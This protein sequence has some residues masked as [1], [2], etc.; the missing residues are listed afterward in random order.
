MRLGRIAL[1]LVWL[2]AGA[3]W[4][5][6]EALQAYLKGADIPLMGL[7][8]L[9]VAM[10]DD[11]QSLIR[12]AKAPG[13]NAEVAARR[14]RLKAYREKSARMGLLIAERMAPPT[15]QSLKVALGKAQVSTDAALD[16]MEK[17]LDGFEGFKAGK[18]EKVFVD[19]S[20]QALHSL[21]AQQ[22]AVEKAADLYKRLAVQA[23][24]K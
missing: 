7:L 21:D 17:A 13:G 12:V 23:L 22:T 10:T 14:A 24:I 20:Q 1:L 15:G 9:N 11:M 5:K 16:A 18:G 6:D 4:A 19:P 2:L 8:E 3:A